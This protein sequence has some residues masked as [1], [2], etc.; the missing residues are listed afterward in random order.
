MTFAYLAS[1][2]QPANWFRRVSNLLL[3]T[4]ST[5]CPSLCAQAQAVKAVQITPP[6]AVSSVAW[7]TNKHSFVVGNFTTASGEVEGYAFLYFSQFKTFVAPKSTNFTRINAINDSNTV[8][9]DF[10]G[11]DNFYHGFII[12]NNG[13]KYSQY[14]VNKGVV[15]TSLFALNNSGSFGGA[16]GSGGPNQGFISVG[17]KVTS[18]YGSG[19]DNT[20]VYGLD[21]SNNSVGT[22]YDSNNNAH[23]FYRAANGTISEVVFPG[24]L[25]TSCQGLNDSGEITGWYEDASGQ[26]HGFTDIGGQF[27]AN[28]FIYTG[29]VSSIGNYVGYYYGPGISSTSNCN[30]AIST[31]CYSYFA[32]P[33]SVGFT[34][35]Q[36]PNAES[37]S[38]Y[39]INNS[40][41]MAGFYTD[42]TGINHGMTLSGNTVTTIDDPKG[43]TGGTSCYGLNNMSEVVGAYLTSSNVTQGF[44]Y[45]NGAYNDIGPSGA[46]SSIA[47]NINDSGAITGTYNDS[48][49]VQHGFIFNNAKYQTVDVP[50]G[51]NTSVF[52]INASGLA[53]V[54]YLGASG[55]WQSAT[56][57]GSKFTGLAVPGAL[58][59]YAH[60]INKSGNVAFSWQDFYGNYHAAVLN[61]GSYYIFDDANGTSSRADGI[62]DGNVMAGRYLLSN[63]DYASYQ[64]SLQ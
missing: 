24:A 22:Y 14:D 11:T 39:S 57:N 16:T 7:G 37:T 4:L 42:S 30:G 26:F 33:V 40:N 50:G 27:R 17:G 44:L 25:Q 48:G 18:F 6:G 23:G 60:A 54:D 28:D 51:T 12:A 13:T 21:D 1:Y 55:F 3:L 49:N 8:V 29:G 43:Q 62:N 45:D 63:G 31:T 2:P 46:L 35:E 32:S 64:A 19:T 10:L 34:N 56:Y 53:T 20:F 58:D 15:S 52:G 5:F 41:V 47:Y 59:T 9:G 36:V 61:G 38:V